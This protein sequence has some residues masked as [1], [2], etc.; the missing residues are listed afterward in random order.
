MDKKAYDCFCKEE[1]GKIEEKE[2]V[3]AEKEINERRRGLLKRVLESKTLNRTLK[4]VVLSAFLSGKAM[5]SKAVEPQVKDAAVD[6]VEQKTEAMPSQRLSENYA[7]L[8]KFADFPELSP[9]QAAFVDHTYIVDHDLWIER[10]SIAVKC[11]DSRYV[12]DLSLTDVACA[13]ECKALPKSEQSADGY[14][15]F[16]RDPGVIGSDGKSTYN[17]I[18]STDFNATKQSI[19]LMYCSNNEQV[20]ALGRQMINGDHAETAERIRRQIYREDGTIVGPEELAKV[21]NGRDFLSLKG[22]IKNL[23]SRSAFNRMYQRVCRSDY[24]NSVAFQ[25]DYALKFYGIGRKGNLNTLNQKVKQAN[26]GKA[27]LTKVRPAVIASALSEMIAKGHG[28]LAANPLALKLKTLNGTAASTNIINARVLGPSARAQADKMAKYDYLTLKLVR[29]MFS[30]TNNLAFYE[31]VNKKI[32][33]HE[34]V[35]EGCRQDLLNRSLPQSVGD[36]LKI[37]SP[38][39]QMRQIKLKADTALLKKFMD[40]RGIGK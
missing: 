32:E 3:M 29:E 26:G 6:A 39:E 17:G 12:Q 21:L 36:G 20:A 37:R 4:T 16:R 25:E 28:T 8:Q 19:V 10:D 1:S 31:A 15:S 13:R 27:D 30:L 24:E 14:I 2:V 38:Q 35:L 7:K 11:V 40:E 5:S 9:A 22:K 34:A 23:G 33:E 18:I